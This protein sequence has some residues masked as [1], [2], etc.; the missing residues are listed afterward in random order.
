MSDLV[1]LGEGDATL[2]WLGLRRHRA[3][4]VVGGVGCGGYWLL[5][6]RSTP[7]ELIMAIV[8]LVGA[9]PA[10]DGLTIAE[11]AM[12]CVGYVVRARW[13]TV[14]AIETEGDIALWATG[15]ASLRGYE[16]RH[17]GRLD[18]A[19][20]DVSIAQALASLLDAA[21]ASRDSRHVSLHVLNCA[22]AKRTLLATPVNV[23]APDGFE[24]CDELAFRVAGLDGHAASVQLLE[25]LT[26][27]RSRDDLRRIYRVRDFTSSGGGALLESILRSSALAELSLHLDVVTGTR[28]QRLAA[29]AVHRVGS[30]DE[31]SH[32]TGFRRTARTARNHSR[33]AQREM[34]VA[35][36]RSLLRL[37]VF[38][39]VRSDSLDE[40]HRQGRAL[41]RDAHDGGLRLERGWGRQSLWHG[42]QLPGGPGW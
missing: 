21:S 35:S 38:V 28:A 32:A 9:A 12:S 37:A 33:M 6:A 26:Y 15:E 5:H 20:R 2:R 24:R 10:V 1:G 42:A 7:V 23:S 16:L 13:Q 31:A 41:W 22:D 17:R 27:L 4:F 29:R 25:R 14:S 34:L 3:M 30:D 19:G 8:L 39:T 18:L 40:L 36:G 11:V